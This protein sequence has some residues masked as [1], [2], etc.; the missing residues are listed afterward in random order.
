MENQMP[1]DEMEIRRNGMWSK[2]HSDISWALS[3]NGKF[4]KKTHIIGLYLFTPFQ[5]VFYN[6]I[7]VQSRHLICELKLCLALITQEFQYSKIKKV[8]W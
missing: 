1:M 4:P 5:K 2:P 3:S 8:A 7:F 6:I